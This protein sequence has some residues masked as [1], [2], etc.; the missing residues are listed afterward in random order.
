MSLCFVIEFYFISFSD[1]IFISSSSLSLCKSGRWVMI[2]VNDRPEMELMTGQTQYHQRQ[3]QEQ[4]G[5]TSS[6]TELRMS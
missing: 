1:D 3:S 4:F 6:K 2:V 5:S